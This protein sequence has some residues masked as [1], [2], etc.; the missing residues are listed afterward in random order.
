MPVPSRLVRSLGPA[1]VGVLK[2]ELREVGT[3]FYVVAGVYFPLDGHGIQ[4]LEKPY[5]LM[6]ETI[7]ENHTRAALQELLKEGNK[8]RKLFRENKTH[9]TFAS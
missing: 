5:Y 8:K 3:R 1:H 7:G 6:V 4:E 2:E 9:T